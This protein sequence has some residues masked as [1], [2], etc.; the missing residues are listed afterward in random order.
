MAAPY[1]LHGVWLSGPTYKVGLMLALTGQKFDYEFVNLREGAHQKPEYKAKNRFA[2]VP[3]LTVAATGRN[4]CQAAA[5]L[6]YLAQATGKFAG[7]SADEQQDIREW[8]LWSY[9][10]FVPPIYRLRAARA[11]F[12]KLDPA[13]TDMYAAEGKVALKLLDDHLKGRNWLVGNGA[14]IADIDLY[15]VA[16]YAPDAGFNLADYPNIQAWMKCFEALPGYGKPEAIL[17]KETR[18]AA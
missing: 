2:V 4:L 3:C 10:R 14:T 13:T 11:G 5:I 1:K 7:A 12:R 9:D 17:P 16:H 6:G 8:M 15:A 18:A